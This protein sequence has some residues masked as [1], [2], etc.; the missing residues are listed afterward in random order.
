MLQHLRGMNTHRVVIVGGGFAGLYAAKSFRSKDV[1]ITI[2]DRRNFHLFQP[3]LYQVATGA[4]SPG[5]IA[6]PLRYVL[7]NRKEISVVLGEVTDIDPAARKLVLADGS[8][9]AYDSL[10]IATGATHSY[11]AHP[12]WAQHAPGLK[13]VEDATEI[14]AR[15][16]LAF[17]RAETAATDE[18]RRA[19]LTFAIVGGGPT[20]V[21]VAGALAE[22]SR[23]TL[24]H[25]FRNI[26]TASARICL[27]EGSPRLL[28]A[29]D[30]ASSAAAERQLR[31]LGVEIHTGSTVTAIDADGVS[32][33]HEGAETRVNAKTVIWAAGVQASPLGKLLA[34]RTGVSLD[35]AGRVIVE[36]DLSLPGHREI[37]VAGDLASGSTNGKPW[38][39]VAPTA[40][41]H[42]AYAAKLIVNRLRDRT[43]APFR[44]WNK[45]S[46]ATIGRNKAVAEVLWALGGRHR[47]DGRH[48]KGVCQAAAQG[49]PRRNPRVAHA[50]TAR[51]DSRGATGQVPGPRRLD[52]RL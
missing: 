3:L 28:H 40:M 36:P 5:E 19:H 7:R 22:I 44:Y 47:R 46:L 48:R 14:R 16:L 51:R 29:F 11:F 34:E 24:K 18:E 45:G 6:S 49:R 17:E 10:L 52:D 1:S 38:P 41:Q 23:D 42:G 8:Q 15:I 37:L 43:T 39:G 30:P 4:L 13:T 12:E 31:S 20:G 35:R 26:D 27:I 2:V 33:Q 50:G 25:D 9:I 32:F 21:E